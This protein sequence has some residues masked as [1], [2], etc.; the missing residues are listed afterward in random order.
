MHICVAPLGR[1]GGEAGDGH[2]G[3]RGVGPSGGGDVPSDGAGLK[4]IRQAAA[5]TRATVGAR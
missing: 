5:D 2:R 4:K 3:G 1:V